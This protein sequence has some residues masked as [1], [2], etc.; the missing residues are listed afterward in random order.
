VLESHVGAPARVVVDSYP[1]DEGPYGARGL[2]GNSRDWCGNVW[3]REGP[4]E[5]GERVILEEET[6]DDMEYRA[7][8]G[9]GWSSALNLARAAVRFGLQ[10]GMR[11]A[12]VGLRVA[13]SFP[14]RRG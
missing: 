3:R 2:S 10:P 7:V 14:P 11:R 1:A 9:G 8:R 6:S 12:T 5:L 13:R 4:P